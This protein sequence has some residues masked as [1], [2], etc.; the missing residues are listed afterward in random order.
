MHQE[1][2]FIIEALM[3][4]LSQLFHG[5]LAMPEVDILLNLLYSLQ[6][7]EGQW[8]FLRL[9]QKDIQGL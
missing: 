1:L 9:T 8:L 2:L 7:L 4:Q 6:V 5:I 3:V